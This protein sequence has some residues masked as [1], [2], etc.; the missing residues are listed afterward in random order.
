MSALTDK[1]LQELADDGASLGWP[2]IAD[3]RAAIAELIA[4]RELCRELLAALQTCYASLNE[5]DH[6]TPLGVQARTAIA[7]AVQP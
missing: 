4:R 6:Q 3:M 1:R 2:E 7:K 5:I